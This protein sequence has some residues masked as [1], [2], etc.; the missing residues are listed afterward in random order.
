MGHGKARRIC[1]A[2]WDE[3]WVGISRYSYIRRIRDP[4]RVVFIASSCESERE[5]RGEIVYLGGS[6]VTSKIRPDKEVSKREKTK[7]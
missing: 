7:W 6:C 1:K 5:R 4:V 2:V 3:W